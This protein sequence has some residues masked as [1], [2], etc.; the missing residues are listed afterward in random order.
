M[1]ASEERQAD[2][3]LAGAARGSLAAALVLLFLSGTFASAA[4][5][6]GCPDHHHHAP[7]PASLGGVPDAGEEGVAPDRQDP[8]DD[9]AGPVCTC[10]GDCQA[11][12]PSALHRP[13]VRDVLQAQTFARLSFVGSPSLRRASR[14][15]YLL[16]YPLG[17]PA[18]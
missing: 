5:I 10:L 3:G 11:G 17:P 4:G 12:A 7:S 14:S 15:E 2:D 6:H 16:P 18:A 9:P 13:P 1:P 8:G